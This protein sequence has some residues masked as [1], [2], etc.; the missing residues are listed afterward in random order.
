MQLLQVV[1]VQV[2]LKQ[3]CRSHWCMHTHTYACTDTHKHIQAHNTIFIL[4]RKFIDPPTHVY[5]HMHTQMRKHT[6]TCMHA[7][8][9]TN[10]LCTQVHNNNLSICKAQNL[11]RINYSKHTHT[12]RHMHTWAFRLCKAKFTQLTLFS[13]FSFQNCLIIANTTSKNGGSRT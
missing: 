13:I 6:N 12:Q 7:C 4:K 2:D 9:C 3:G 10:K 1:S 5:M 8:A 11:V